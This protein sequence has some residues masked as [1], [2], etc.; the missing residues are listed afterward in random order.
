MYT[1]MGSEMLTIRTN[2][3]FVKLV[4]NCK[5]AGTTLTHPG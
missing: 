4:K 3:Q 2:R 5:I 1:F